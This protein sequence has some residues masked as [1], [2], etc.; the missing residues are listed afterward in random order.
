MDEGEASL[1][2]TSGAFPAVQLEGGVFAGVA[3]QYFRNGERDHRGKSL[4][5]EMH[6]F[7]NE[8]ITKVIVSPSIWEVP[9]HRNKPMMHSQKVVNH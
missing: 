4:V 9:N 3:T 2:I 8:S 1:G 6:D 5:R 7:A